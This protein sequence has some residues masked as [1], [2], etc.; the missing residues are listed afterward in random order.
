MITYR[1]LF[2]FLVDQ[3]VASAQIRAEKVLPLPVVSDVRS[4]AARRGRLFGRKQ[5]PGTLSFRVGRNGAPTHTLKAK[6]L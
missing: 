6:K 3:R 1:L 5:E 2:L 4:K